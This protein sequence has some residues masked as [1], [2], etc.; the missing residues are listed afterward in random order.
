MDDGVMKEYP[1]VILVDTWL[2]LVKNQKPEFDHIQFPLR[3]LIKYYFGTME[4]AELYVEQLKDDE[5]DIY[6]V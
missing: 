6:F 2:Y 3:Q 4:L 1:P 5:I